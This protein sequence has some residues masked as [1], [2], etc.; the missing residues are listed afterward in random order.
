MAKRCEVQI[1]YAI[2]R[3]EPVSVMVDTFG[4]GV[5]SDSR[6]E[7]AV[8]EVFDLTP[9]A[10]IRDLALNKPIYSGLACYGH[11]G[12]MDLCVPWEVANRKYDLLTAALKQKEPQKQ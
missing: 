3:C 7:A 1:A 5:I 10:I 9:A 4:T 6:I 11:F 12:R 8:K 2:G